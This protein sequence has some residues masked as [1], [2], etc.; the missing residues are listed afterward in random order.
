MILGWT[1]TQTF[2]VTGPW[3]HPL[4]PGADAGPAIMIQV[5]MPLRH[6]NG[7][8]RAEVPSLLGL[9]IATVTV[10]S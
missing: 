4:A 10:S 3:G 1:R 9:P 8:R 6:G 2:Q 7:D 5:G